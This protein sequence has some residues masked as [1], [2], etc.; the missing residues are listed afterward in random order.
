MDCRRDAKGDDS[1]GYPPSPYPYHRSREGQFI[2]NICRNLHVGKTWSDE[3]FAPAFNNNI[4]NN[5]GN[6]IIGF[7][8]GTTTLN[9]ATATF[10]NLP[11]NASADPWYSFTP[12]V[13]LTPADVGL[14]APDP[15]CPSGPQS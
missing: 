11:W 15:L 8:V 9:P 1:H 10:P 14:A 4:W 3:N 7:E 5:T 12:A 6:H 2:G 13:K